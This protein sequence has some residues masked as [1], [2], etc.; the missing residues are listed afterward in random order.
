[1]LKAYR[2]NDSVATPALE[3]SGRLSLQE[4]LIPVLE[5]H[6]SRYAKDCSSSG[7]TFFNI[8]SGNKTWKTEVHEFQVKN[9]G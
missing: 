4:A 6:A 2:G 7:V 5:D 9:T 3:V 1:M 8:V